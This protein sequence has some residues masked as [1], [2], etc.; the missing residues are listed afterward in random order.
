MSPV[1]TIEA[2]RCEAGHSLIEVLVST[3]LAAVTVL[4][5]SAGFLSATRVSRVSERQGRVVA[6]AQERLAFL[7]ADAAANRPFAPG[8][9]SGG[10]FSVA[11]EQ[12]VIAGLSAGV[13]LIR[14]TV[15]WSGPG[16]GS[17]RFDTLVDNAT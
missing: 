9:S 1:Q 10:D 15:S 7:V 5:F 13:T 8:T 3:L 16:A 6:L 11:W 14:V 12:P 17:Y 2:S 4:G